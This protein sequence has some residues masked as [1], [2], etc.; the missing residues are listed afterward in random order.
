MSIEGMYK[1]RIFHS[2]LYDVTD[3]FTGVLLG[4]HRFSSVTSDR[5]EI[6]NLERHHCNGIELLSGL[7]CSK[8][9][10]LNP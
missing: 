9:P 3:D 10:Y 7:M 1:F 8:T 6:G 5:S 4:H 2:L